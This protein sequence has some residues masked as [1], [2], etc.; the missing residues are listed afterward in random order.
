MQKKKKKPDVP[1]SAESA[2]TSENVA[3][4][5]SS[6]IGASAAVV[7]TQKNDPE[8]IAASSPPAHPPVVATGTDEPEDSGHAMLGS[9]FVV[10]LMTIVSRL[11]GLWRFRVM[12]SFFGASGVADA[13]NFAFIFPNLTRRLFGEGLLTSVFVP[14]FSDRL[15][16]GEKDAANRTA[17]VLLI[18]LTYFL[19][20]ICVAIVAVSMLVRLTLAG[21]MGF[22]ENTLLAFKLFEALLPYCVVIN[23]AAV[24]MAILNSLGHFWMPAFAP[25]LLNVLVVAAC[26]FGLSLFGTPPEAQIWAVVIAVLI[27]GFVQ[28]FVQIPPARAGGF[29]FTFK[30]DPSD[31]GYLEVMSNFKPVVLMVAVFQANVLMDNLIAQWF[32]PGSGPVTYMNMGTSVYQM[33]WA[34]IALAIGVAALP[35]LSRQWAQEKTKEFHSTLTT[36][37]RYAVFASIP[38]TVGALL[39]SDDI[40][41]FLY[42][43]GKFLAHDGEPVRRTSGVVFYSCLG[44]VFYS[45]NSILVRALYAMKDMKTPTRTLFHSVLLN[46]ILN[47]FFVLIAPRIAE[48]LRGTAENWVKLS[49][50]DA[51]QAGPSTAVTRL[52]AMDAYNL[53]GAFGNLR[54]SGIILASTISTA[55][56]TWALAKAVRARLTATATPAMTSD[57]SLKIF[58]VAACSA[59]LG[60]AVYRYYAT[61]DKDSE[62]LFAFGYGAAAFLAPMIFIGQDFCAR[63]FKVVRTKLGLNDD[64]PIPIDQI[65]EA[66]KFQHALFTSLSASAVMGLMVWAV[67]DSLPPEGRTGLQVA[68]R[69]L[70]PVVAG[71]LV[72]SIASSALM[73]REYEELTMLFRRKFTRGK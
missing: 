38:C 18:R 48:A 63:Q 12:G 60:L 30:N 29:K 16:K 43:A 15:A 71:I 8:D 25:V 54:E 19:S 32:I 40:V 45:V 64:D 46:L 41:R 35:M 20:F 58:G 69:A 2:G 4:T 55:W 21:P 42:G 28:L 9:A 34:I 65:P 56:Q 27:G 61:K 72:Y 13:F 52:F 68:Q 39:L 1:K 67:R 33:A 51:A 11:T 73:S 50:T 6:E 10:G 3:P 17:S 14:V 24:L 37:L 66:L 26:Y 31:P 59:L 23:V 62:T 36:A 7:A 57:F 49:P 70:A 47:L 5:L 44:L 53:V 22:S